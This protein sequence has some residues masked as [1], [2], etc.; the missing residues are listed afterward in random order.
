MVSLA[1]DGI[2]NELLINLGKPSLMV[3]YQV[4]TLNPIQMVITALA[5]KF[6][7]SKIAVMVI[8]AFIL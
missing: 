8:L 2:I 3:A 5:S 7:I 6:G 4:A 1:R